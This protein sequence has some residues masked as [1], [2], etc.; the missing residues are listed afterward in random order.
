[1]V[2]KLLA[3]QQI[4]IKKNIMISGHQGR[5][6]DCKWPGTLSF[7]RGMIW[8]LQHGLYQTSVRYTHKHITDLNE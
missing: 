4:F 2:F 6:I 3:A 1:M 7:P 8:I 5:G